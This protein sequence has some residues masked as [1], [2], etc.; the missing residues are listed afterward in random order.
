MPPTMKL[1]VDYAFK[2]LSNCELQATMANYILGLQ[3][4]IIYSRS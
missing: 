1:A 4:D 2:A 3:L